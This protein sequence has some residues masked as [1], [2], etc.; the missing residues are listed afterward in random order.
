MTLNPLTVPIDIGGTWRICIFFGL[1]LLCFHQ[2]FRLLP[3]RR[4]LMLPEMALWA[5]A[6]ICALY[7]FQYPGIPFSTYNTA[8]QAT[9]GQ[10]FSEILLI[11]LA[12]L[13][14]R[15]RTQD[16]LLKHF[17]WIA[18]AELVMVWFNKPALLN[19][20]SF[21]LAM[22][23]CYFPFAPT[24]LRG[25]T[26]GTIVFNHS[27][28]AIII[29]GVQGFVWFVKEK[30]Y[31]ALPWTVWAT[32]LGVFL[33]V[34]YHFQTDTYGVRVPM[35]NYAERISIYQKYLDWWRSNWSFIAFGVGPGTFMWCALLIDKFK[36]PLFLQMHSDWLQILFELGLVG[37][38][39]SLAVYAR[40]ILRVWNDT[41]QV[42][43]LAGIGAFCLTYHPLRFFP[44]AM[45]VGLIF[46]RGIRSKAWDQAE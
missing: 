42:M 24:W 30:Q 37:L 40:A 19:A 43:A 16:R 33:G 15:A 20:A 35:F 13:T 11:P 32:I 41:V 22:V 38:T 6:L 8:F 17:K 14:M 39:L 29:L 27:G 44:S 5:Y 21:D 36:P 18:L 45:L 9:A 46:A 4:N 1:S 2:I 31:E 3:S 23:A 7:L 26:L 12:L 28:T 34:C 10:S 25:L